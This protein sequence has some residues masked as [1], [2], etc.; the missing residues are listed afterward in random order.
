M[1]K[2]F[3][4]HSDLEFVKVLSMKYAEITLPSFVCDAISAFRTE[5]HL[6]AVHKVVYAVF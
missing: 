4:T 1:V 2:V 5:H 6:A 3:I